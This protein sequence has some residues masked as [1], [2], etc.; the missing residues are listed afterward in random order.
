M[1]LPLEGIKV[2]DMTIVQAGPA[3]SQLM[4]WYGADV[5]KVERVDGGDIT[6]HQLRDIPNVDALY[7]TTLNSNKRS[8]TLNTKTPEGTRVLEELIRR[9]DIMVEN[10]GPGALDR[11]GFVPLKDPNPLCGTLPG[12]IAIFTDHRP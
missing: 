10:F 11:M 7:F 1:S 8:L 12:C 9:S 3:C 5:I 6:R 4:A 2:I